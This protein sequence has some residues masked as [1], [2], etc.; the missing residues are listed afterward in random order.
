MVS[1]DAAAWC[2]CPWICISNNSFC[3][4]SMKQ[5]IIK[6]YLDSVFVISG[7]QGLGKC[8]QPWPPS[9]AN[10][11]Y[12]DLDYPGYHKNLIQLLFKIHSAK[13]AT[14]VGYLPDFIFFIAIRRFS[15]E[16]VTTQYHKVLTGIKSQSYICMQCRL[17]NLTQNA[18]PYT[19][20]TQLNSLRQR[21]RHSRK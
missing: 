9:S 12:L 16:F 8:N 21:I 4:F 10:Y 17:G 13:K 15:M 3:I 1:S 2:V 5:C 19:S 11:T 6:Q 14:D 7:N 18:E 20:S